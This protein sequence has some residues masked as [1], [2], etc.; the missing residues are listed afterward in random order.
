MNSLKMSVFT[1]AL[2]F[3]MGAM[4]TD[5]IDRNSEKDSIFDSSRDCMGLTESDRALCETEMKS[6]STGSKANENS[7]INRNRSTNM[8]G[9]LKSRDVNT[10]DLQFISNQDRD[11]KPSSTLPSSTIPSNNRP[12]NNKPDNV[13]PRD[14]EAKGTQLDGSNTRKSTVDKF[15]LGNTSNPDIGAGSTNSS[16]SNSSKGSSSDSKPK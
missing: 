3:S 10:R 6:D 8:R 5:N 12:S 4:A 13:T 15:K 1:L 2:S 14:T 9:D 7:R 11:T 16:T